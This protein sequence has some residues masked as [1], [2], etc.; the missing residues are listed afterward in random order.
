MNAD[1]RT[2]LKVKW[3]GLIMINGKLWYCPVWNVN[4][5][6]RT[7]YFFLGTSRNKEN[8]AISALSTFSWA[9][10]QKLRCHISEE[11]DSSSW[12][13]LFG[14]MHL[15]FWLQNRLNNFHV[16]DVTILNVNDSS[17]MYMSTPLAHQYDEHWKN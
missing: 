6:N 12:K 1:R 2:T 5:A 14:D 10:N 13:I 4:W 11:K 7:E 16:K 15:V 17:K 8:P 9:Y 3:I